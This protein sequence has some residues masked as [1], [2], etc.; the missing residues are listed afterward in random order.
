[1]TPRFSWTTEYMMVPFTKIENSE[2]KRFPGCR[3][4]ENKFG[5]AAF[6]LSV[7]RFKCLISS[8]Q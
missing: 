5:H 1:M 2:G 8:R 3:E 7:K 6:A 4:W